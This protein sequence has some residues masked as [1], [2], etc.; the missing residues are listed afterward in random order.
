MWYG[1]KLSV[2]ISDLLHSEAENKMCDAIRCVAQEDTSW[3]REHSV[4]VIEF[5][6]V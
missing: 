3:F 4:G 6:G 1:L 5:S 2:V